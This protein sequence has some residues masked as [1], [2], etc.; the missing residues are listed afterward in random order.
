MYTLCLLHSIPLFSLSTRRLIIFRQ[1]E[2]FRYTSIRPLG[3]AR[4]PS[5]RGGR[6]RENSSRV[7][8]FAGR[9]A[10]TRAVHGSRELLCNSTPHTSV[11]VCA[12][13]STRSQTYTC[14]CT[15]RHSH[16]THTWQGR[17][18]KSI[19]R[20]VFSLLRAGRKILQSA[21]DTSTE[22]KSCHY[23]DAL[24]MNFARTWSEVSGV[25]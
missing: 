18:E 16:I 11:S 13:V 4:L 17:A 9:R 25:G 23:F 2:N 19:Y 10:A 1:R 20:F 14:T 15:Y 7:A 22:L 3:S 12:L 6:K 21:V 5:R 8:N 24:E